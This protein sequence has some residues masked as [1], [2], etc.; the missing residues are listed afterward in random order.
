V[1]GELSP[2]QEG[3]LDR[4]LGSTRNLH[5]RIDDI[6]FFVQLDSDDVPVRREP[7]QVRELL[8][9]VMAVLPEQPRVAL[10]VGVSAA[11]E[12]VYTDPALLRRILFH[13]LDNAFK[14]TAAGEVSVRLEEDG[15]DGVVL[16]VCDTGIGFAPERLREL[17]EVFTQ[18]DGSTTRRYSGMGMGLSLVERCVR[19]LG[20]ELQA[21]SRPGGGSRFHLALP[22]ASRST[23]RRLGPGARA[24]VSGAAPNPGS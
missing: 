21:D 22:G 17:A 11:A 13:L 2:E 1:G 24:A 5:A 15:R 7:V 9:E 6:L 3:F 14:F 20:G 18:G 12:T 4:V 16:S 19:L 8:S 10:A 23:A